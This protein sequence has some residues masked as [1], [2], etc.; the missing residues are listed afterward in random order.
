[1]KEVSLKFHDIAFH[2]LK[3]MFSPTFY[4]FKFTAVFIHIENAR[5]EKKIKKEM[6]II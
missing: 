5:E 6:T 1:M 3:K 4:F 2:K